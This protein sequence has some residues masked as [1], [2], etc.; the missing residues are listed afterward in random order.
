MLQHL[1]TGLEHKLGLLEKGLDPN[2]PVPESPPVQ[3]QS[4]KA[5]QAAVMP[6]PTERPAPAPQPAP[7]PISAQAKKHTGSDPRPAA[8]IAATTGA[9]SVPSHKDSGIGRERQ[10]AIPLIRKVCLRFHPVVRQLR[11]RSDDRAP[12]EVED[13][14]DVRDLLRALLSMEFEDISTEEWIPAYTN[15]KS[16]TVIFLKAEGIVVDVKKTRPG[17]GAKEL[18]EQATTDFQ[19][20][21]GQ[22]CHTVFCFIYDPEGRIPN[23]RRLETDLTGNNAGRNTEALVSPK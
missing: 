7:A 9:P 6:P 22:D 10:E 4:A 11:Q 12:L 13:E 16:R 3:K 19:Q 23:P 14:T 18:A 5:T 2:Q 17:L 21:P 20:F 1:I 15:G 8:T